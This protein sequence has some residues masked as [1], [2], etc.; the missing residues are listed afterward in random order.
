VDID[1]TMKA[2]AAARAKGG[3]VLGSGAAVP[4]LDPDDLMR[5]AAVRIDELQASAAQAHN[6]AR[7]LAGILAALITKIVETTGKEKEEDGRMAFKVDP[8]LLARA[9]G[10]RLN[11]LPQEDG[12]MGVV[13]QLAE[14]FER[15]LNEELA[16]SVG[17]PQ[18]LLA[19]ALAAVPDNLVEETP[20]EA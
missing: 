5:L 4:A 18:E 17:D 14:D 20:N 19:N 11:L 13:I 6:M 15:I 9:N 3:V 16:E 1:E 8:E 2:E 12:S 10:A 7:T